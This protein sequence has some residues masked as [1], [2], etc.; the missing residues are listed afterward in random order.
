MLSKAGLIIALFSLL[1]GSCG[2]GVDDGQELTDAQKFLLALKGTWVGTADSAE[3]ASG[4]DRIVFE[5]ILPSDGKPSLEGLTGYVWFG[6]ELD[7]SPV[8][9]D[10]PGVAWGDVYFVLRE[11]YRFE[12]QDMAIVSDRLFAKFSVHS[13]W[14]EFCEAQTEV[15]ERHAGSQG[16]VY[17]CVPDWGTSSDENDENCIMW[18]PNGEEWPYKCSTIELCQDVCDCD[19]QS[20]TIDESDGPSHEL[21]INV[22]IENGVMLGTGSLGRIEA[23]KQ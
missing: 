19:S 16:I 4:T 20:C 18:G 9:P 12:L 21:D 17:H 13:Q 6:E 3:T 2:E 14:A 1:L 15:Y 5:M 8:N 7:T 11:G 22:D 10:D 23:V